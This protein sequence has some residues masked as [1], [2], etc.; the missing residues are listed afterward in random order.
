ML[1]SSKKQNSE[2]TR[3]FNDLEN[4][5]LGGVERFWL[6]TDYTMLPTPTKI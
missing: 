1:V 3:L 5:S 2:L 4:V 6:F